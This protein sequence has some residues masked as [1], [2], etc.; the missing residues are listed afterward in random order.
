MRRFLFIVPLFVLSIPAAAQAQ[1][2]IKT[3]WK[4]GVVQPTTA[5][6]LPGQ[7]DHVY[8]VYKVNC[9]A[10]AGEI[11]GVKQKEG[12][13]TEFADAKPTG[14]MGHGIF[15]E[16]LENGDTITYK[17]QM[18]TTTKDKV[19]QSASNTWTI[20]GGTGKLKG[21]TGTGTCKGK[22]D[23][24]GTLSLLCTGGYTLAK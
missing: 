5:V 7:T 6:P 2:P 8:S 11:A 14:A 12:T 13:A 16:T 20:A 9:T 4:C 22:G 23:A 15:V 1:S 17:Y 18:T 19:V 3:T 24:E 10:D 21:I